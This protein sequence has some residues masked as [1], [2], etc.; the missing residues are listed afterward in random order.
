MGT[1]D[2]R[3]Q[4]GKLTDLDD[5]IGRR[6]SDR[7]EVS[8]LGTLLTAARYQDVI[9]R[10]LSPLGARFWHRK[11]FCER[12]AL[13]TCGRIRVWGRIV[14]HANGLAGM[15]F[16]HAIDLD[17]VIEPLSGGSATPSFDDTAR[18]PTDFVTMRT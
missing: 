3:F 4:R 8:L 7:R 16:D 10:D 2:A 9:V 11:P 5:L 15:A 6:V 1:R 18:F 13:L 17:T 12:R 14:W